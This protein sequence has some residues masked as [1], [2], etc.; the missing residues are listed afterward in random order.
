GIM[1]ESLQIIEHPCPI[2]G[3]R[4]HH[5]YTGKDRLHGVGGD[6]RYAGCGECGAVFQYPMPDIEQILAFYPGD[7]KPYAPPAI[8]P[9]NALK[10]AVLAGAYGYEHL[11][12]PLPNWLGRLAAPF[13][14]SKSIPFVKHGTL[15]D[16]GCGNGKF[17]AAMQQFGWRTSGVEFNPQAVDYCRRAGLDVHPGELGEAEFADAS[18]DAVT[19]NHV[20]E[21]IAEPRA[22]IAEIARI[23]KTGGTLYL[24]TPN[25]RALGRP[26]FGACWFANDIPRHLVLYDKQNLARLA[27]GAGLQLQKA[28]TRSTPKIILNSW[29]ACKGNQGKPSRKRPLRRL[30]GKL[31]AAVSS[32]VGRGDE[33]LASFVK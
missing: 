24:R 32:L 11:H 4:A 23:L 16:V 22:F 1:Q 26:W 3:G 30:P 2:C 31:Y 33:L 19:A 13:I 15:L 7:Y 14:Y 29:D 12:S 17:L 10:R 20:I 21:H 8:R 6:F 27:V 18:F 5:A 25:S 9:P 28:S